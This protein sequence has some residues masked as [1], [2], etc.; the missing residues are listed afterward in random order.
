MMETVQA[1]PV[2]P[3][4]SHFRFMHRAVIKA[5]PTTM[6]AIKIHAKPTMLPRSKSPAAVKRFRKPLT[7]MAKYKKMRMD[8]YAI[9]KGFHPSFFIF[10]LKRMEKPSANENPLAKQPG[11]KRKERQTWPASCFILTSNPK[12]VKSGAMRR[13]LRNDDFYIV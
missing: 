1:R 12:G 9:L 3:A 6:V 5:N 2:K 13:A 7:V 4:H 11:N 10:S 8:L